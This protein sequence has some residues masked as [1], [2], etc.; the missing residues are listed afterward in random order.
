MTV[1]VLVA[2]ALIVESGGS[3]GSGGSRGV[4][5][6]AC[7]EGIGWLF[8]ISFVPLFGL[9]PL[10]LWGVAAA[11]RKAGCLGGA[12][13]MLAGIWPGA[14]LF[15]LGHGDSLDVAWSVPR[16]KGDIT[17]QGF[18][19]GDGLAVRA[20]IDG[21]SAYDTATGAPKWTLPVPGREVL[22]AMS[23][24]TDSGVGV[25]AYG[26]EGQPCGHFVGV[27]L[28]TG[29]KAWD[30]VLPGGEFLS[31]GR[32][33]G[34]VA[35]G[36]GTAV[37]RLGQGARLTGVA[38][39]D[40]RDRWT[41]AAPER[42]HY[43][44]VSAGPDQIVGLL[45]CTDALPELVALE[46]A[47]GKVAWRTPVTSESPVAAVDLYTASPAVAKVRESGARGRTMIQAFDRTGRATIVHTWSDDHDL[48]LSERGFGATPLRD[49][50]VTGDMIVGATRVSNKDGLTAFRLSDG[51][52][53]W[54]TR[55][56]HGLEALTVAGD[57][58]IVLGDGGAVPDLT[59]VALATGKK[60]RLGGFPLR[61]LADKVA[62]S[63]E[64]AGRYT[65]VAE[66]TNPF[67]DALV[68]V[69]P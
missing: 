69:R 2:Q 59:S 43:E 17:A 58:L 26:P 52:R 65:L 42:C 32:D 23:R 12:V 3:C 14:L 48:T 34:S 64:P 28:A 38:L 62:L 47:S 8:L 66:S 41:A 24:G 16:V 51:A 25:I 33:A 27:D 53:L 67:Y 35:A 1:Q 36:G 10:A 13:L 44:K 11:G 6:G 22:C 29:A 39:A 18:W 21:L 19:F 31:S 7:P 49:F 15:R 57:A 5:H 45:R 68:G 54:L 9:V 63:A 30:R 55:L 37:M 60:T 4:S 40:G 20:R 50:A 46:P 56:D 61:H